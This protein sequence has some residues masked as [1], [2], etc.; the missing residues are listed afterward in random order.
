[1]NRAPTFPTR[2][3]ERERHT[4]LASCA[5]ARHENHCPAAGRHSPVAGAVARKRQASGSAAVSCGFHRP[6]CRA[7]RGRAWRRLRL[8]APPALMHAVW[9]RRALLLRVAFSGARRGSNWAPITT[10]SG[11]TNREAFVAYHRVANPCTGA[12]LNSRID[13]AAARCARRPSPGH[14]ARG[15]VPRQPCGGPAGW[16]ARSSAAPTPGAAARCRSA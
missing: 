8:R 12:P 11:G 3:S 16:F 1:M 9:T 2:S 4:G 15:R 10:T 13:R 7:C 5:T 14:S 6:E